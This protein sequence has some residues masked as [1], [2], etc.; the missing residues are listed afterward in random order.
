MKDGVDMLVNLAEMGI[1]RQLYPEPDIETCKQFHPESV[2]ALIILADRYNLPAATLFRKSIAPHWLISA[3]R[4]QPAD[5]TVKNS[6]HYFGVAFDVMVGDIIKQIEFV[7]LA[8]ETTKLFNRGGIYVGRNTCHIDQCDD[9]WMRKYNGTKFWVW[10]DKKYV[11]FFNFS[12]A[13]Q[14]ALDLIAPGVKNDR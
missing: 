5:A 14:Y 1:K 11:G 12:E 3:F 10:H 4:D 2:G 13:S 8:V 9:A 7:S 6:P